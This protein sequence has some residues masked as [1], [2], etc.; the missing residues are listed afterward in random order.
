MKIDLL[1]CHL[2]SENWGICVEKGSIS[3]VNNSCRTVNQMR[4][5][6]SKIFRDL[7]KHF[8]YSTYKA[9]FMAKSTE[10][11]GSIFS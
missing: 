7:C 9:Y 11:D 3:L 10:Q 8:M 6:Y 5:I 4:Q 2:P 1:E